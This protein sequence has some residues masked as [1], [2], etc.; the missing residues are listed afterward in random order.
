VLVSRYV[1]LMSKVPPLSLAKCQDRG[2]TFFC[3]EVV[4]R[5][6]AEPL[7]RSV[8]APPNVGEQLADLTWGERGQPFV[9]FGA[10]SDAVLLACLTWLEPARVGGRAGVW[11]LRCGHL[12][13]YPTRHTP[14]RQYAVVHDVYRCGTERQD[15]MVRDVAR[16]GVRRVP[17]W[18][19]DRGI[20]R[21]ESTAGRRPGVFFQAIRGEHP[22]GNLLPGPLSFRCT[23]LAERHRGVAAMV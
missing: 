9:E 4:R 3:A 20:T 21:G 14:E 15:D 12:E 23:W 2:G 19:K 5:V 1:V 17:F 10:A 8:Y 22:S 18:E 7:I 13:I 6:L 11:L 16:H